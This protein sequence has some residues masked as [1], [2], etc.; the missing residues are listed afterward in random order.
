MESATRYIF[1]ERMIMNRR[2]GFLGLAMVLLIVSV[3][4]AEH[5]HVWQQDSLTDGLFGLNDALEPKGIE[6]TFSLTNIYQAN[7]KGG[8][9][10]HRRKGRWSGSYDLE[11]NADMEKLLGVEN[12]ALYMHAEGTWSRQDIDGTSVGSAFGVN[13]DFA[14]RESFNII[15]LWYQ[16][17]FFSDT[18]QLRVGKLDMTGGFECRSCPVSF[19]G[20]MYA[21]DE[22]TQFL[23]AAL[24]NNPTIPFPDYGLGAVVYWNP[25]EQWYMSFGAADAQADKRETGFNTTFHDEDYF[26][27]MAETGVTPHLHSDKGILP[28]AYRVGVWYDP[29][30]K[31]HSDASKEYRDD[32]GFYLSCDQKLVNENH[33]SADMQGLGSFFRYGYAPS[34]TND[35][36]CFYSVGLQYQGLFEGRDDDVLAIG[37]AHGSFSDRADITYTEDYESV[38]ELYYSAQV[39]RWM[40]LS[41]SLQYV[42]NPGG[43]SSISDAV[44]LG[45]RALINF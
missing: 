43:D 1:Y 18:L 9:S 26:I 39:T 25:V 14:P 20:N 23:N 6:F 24:V 34:R 5:E 32:T 22:N 29:Q 45:L 16:Q 7:V 13:G 21:N 27:Y 11:M 17:S 12:A 37:Y 33:D 3:S 35:I 42:T 41:P 38:T 36:S 15:E 4:V 2:R 19:D 31:A 10:T 28:G 8:S 30:P 40:T 44:V